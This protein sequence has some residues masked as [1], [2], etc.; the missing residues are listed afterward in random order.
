MSPL[1]V[2]GKREGA[3]VWGQTLEHC[4]KSTCMC[5]RSECPNISL[6]ALNG[7]RCDASN[8]IVLTKPSKVWFNCSY[9]NPPSDTE[10][11]WYLDDVRQAEFND[12]YSVHISIPSGRHR[13]ECRTRIFVTTDCMCDDS[14]YIDCS[15][16][17]TYDF[18]SFISSC[19]SSQ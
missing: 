17:G 5:N 14:A 19:S 13:V 16:V 12:Q 6:V 11:S 15:V 2:E 9:D 7:S 8:E 3:G 4:S 10:Y 1:R 18:I